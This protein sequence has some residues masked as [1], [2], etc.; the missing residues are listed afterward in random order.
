MT[1]ICRPGA[2]YALTITAQ[3]T[4]PKNYDIAKLSK[5]ISTLQNSVDMGINIFPPDF[6]SL[7]MTVFLDVRFAASLNSSSQLRTM[8]TFMDK[9]ENANIV[10]YGNPKSNLV[11]RLVL[12]SKVFSVVHG[13]NFL[14]TSRLTFNAMLDHVVPLSVYAAWY[15]FSK[16]PKVC[17]D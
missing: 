1:A 7:K 8:I 13:F 5:I 11:I 12:A 2:I 14:S 3:I 17:Y 4:D 6:Y 9:T 15:T 10:D 16:P